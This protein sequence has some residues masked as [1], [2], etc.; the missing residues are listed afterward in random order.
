M[1]LPVKQ[2]AVG[3]KNDRESGAKWP[4][5]APVRSVSINWLGQSR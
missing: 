1:V 2:D 3:A 5:A 4:M